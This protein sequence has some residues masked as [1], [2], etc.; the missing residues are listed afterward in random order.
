MSRRLAV[1][2]LSVRHPMGQQ[3]Y[4]REIVRRAPGALGQGWA[5]K[6]ISVG[7]VVPGSRSL[8]VPGRVIAVDGP[9][10]RRAVGRAVHAGYDLVH[11]TDLRLPPAPREVLTVHDAVSWRYPD[12]GAP[13]FAAVTEVKEARAV[14]CPS[15]F[16]ADEVHSVLGVDP[17][18]IPNGVDE[19]AFTASP[20]SPSTLRGLGIT[21]PFVLHAG[22]SSLRKNLEGLA[23]AWPLVARARPDLSLV[24]IGP[25]SARRDRLFRDLP[26]TVL[27]GWV[28]AEARLSLLASAAVV[29]LPSLYEG[30]GL[31]PL[32]AMAVG[33][34]V[35]A[36]RRAAL[37]EV[38]GDAAHL[39]EPDPR[40]LADGILDLLDVDNPD[41][42][43]LVARGRDRAARMT[44][45]GSVAAHAELWR[46]VA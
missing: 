9:C 36:A 7:G 38:C 45:A 21:G 20:A 28:D 6:A 33:T 14:V 41:V 40:S 39:V 19:A 27:P 23:G 4:D 30:F 24:L 15:Q 3:A 25:Y 8:R 5:V 1:T 35:V 10:L 37:P 13:P 16:S 12:E 22:G 26:A 2:V 18:A 46:A 44:W 42:R 31:P 17:V 11:R 32:E 34:P 29:V 43:A